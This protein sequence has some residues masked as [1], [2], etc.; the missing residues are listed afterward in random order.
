MKANYTKALTIIS[1]LFFQASFAQQ[2]KIPIKLPPNLVRPGEFLPVDTIYVTGSNGNVA[3]SG[4]QII[5]LG[6][7]QDENY[8]YLTQEQ[9]IQEVL[10]STPQEK[11]L[12]A[13]SGEAFNLTFA[14]KLQ[15]GN[16]IS[17]YI[18]TNGGYQYPPTSGD[19][20]Q[21]IQAY[22]GQEDI[23]NY[24][25]Q[26]SQILSNSNT[27]YENGG[28]TK[29]VT[30]TSSLTF[31]LGR[32][33]SW[34]VF[35]FGLWQRDEFYNVPRY[36]K[37]RVVI[38][39]VVE[40]PMI[41]PSQ[42]NPVAI[43]GYIREPAIP[44]FILHNPPGDM[45]SV[46]FQTNQEACR[47]MSESLT[48]DETNNGKLDVTLGIAGSAGLFVSVNYEFSVTASLSGG[49]GSTL[50]KSSGKQNCVSVLNAISTVPGNA[51]ANEGS[52]Y[53]GY[54]SDIAYGMFPII[55]I[56]S[57][58]TVSVVRDS[59]V[60][61]GLVPGSAT[62]FYYTK[63]DILNDISL[64]RAIMNNMSNTPKMR[65]QAQS[66]IKI[67]EQVLKKD[68]TNINDP[69]SPVIEAPFTLGSGQSRTTSVTQSIS[70]TDTYEVSH[71]LELGAGLSFVVK[72][73]GSGVAGGY[74]FKTKKTRGASVSNSNNSSTTIAYTLQ[75]N[76][77]GDSFRIKIVKDKSYGTPIFL[78]DEA[79][80]RTSCPYEGGYQRDQPRLEIVGTS[81]NAINVQNVTLGTPASFQVRVC[82]NNTTEARDY[83]L[84]FVAQSNSSDLLITAAGSTGSEFGAFTIPANSC[85]V[86]NYDV[87]VSRRYPTSDVNFPNL[88]FRLY[89]ECEPAIKSSIFASVGYA[90][91]P[92]S[93]VSAN[94]TAVCTGSPVTLTATC[95]FNY[96]TNWYTSFTGGIV[97]ASGGT[98]TVNP[99]SNTVYYVGCESLNHVP[100]R[101]ASK[102]VVVGTPSTVLN[103]TS[104]YT[105]DSFQIA[106]TTIT[107]TN[108]IFSPASVLYKAGNS[109]TFNPGFEAKS[110]SNF[111]AR[112]G[113]CGN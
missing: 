111:M 54:S 30:Y 11:Y 93:T 71:F 72:V 58:P 76:D 46:T 62:P 67:W 51:R 20:D 96:T 43:K 61:F 53:I 92:P 108:K 55:A 78:I 97:V 25:N 28:N 63:S 64:N 37:Y 60:I 39:F 18:D 101:V 29:V 113:G 99:T 26:T 112:I 104:N 73:G 12:K 59:S 36:N 27:T 48:T 3:S 82:N 103:L 57:T 100:A 87:N 56:N 19:D 8:N 4:I 94:N 107:A 109:L 80:T 31:N 9:M 33:K 34:Y 105:T 40:G 1:I 86:Q 75:D 91:P 16:Y 52:I 23:T 22:A 70:T 17:P 24:P 5:S 74:E 84:G 68:S 21:S 47:S 10:N 69:T 50:M 15:A 2:L 49:G 44:Q 13:K 102:M 83:R 110:G 79:L 42:A 89:T 14:F 66:Q 6:R 95:P 98:V 85:R 90:A 45:S 106:N 65:H 32:F 81:Q 38:P 77:A 7:T 41:T 88:E 35:T